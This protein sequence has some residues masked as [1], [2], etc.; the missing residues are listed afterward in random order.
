MANATPCPELPDLPFQVVIA[1][2]PDPERTNLRL[3]FDRSMEAITN[4]AQDTGYTL[5]RYS[6]PWQTTAPHTY[7]SLADDNAAQAQRKEKNSYPGILAFRNA[8]GG[9]A[10]AVLLVG[11]SPTEGY[12][13]SQLEHALSFEPQLA[14]AGEPLS[15][16]GPCFSG[17]L[18]VLARAIETQEAFSSRRLKI[19]SGTASAGEAW[20]K[21]NA[22]VKSHEHRI[23]S[24]TF[25]RTNE[26][27]MHVLTDFLRTNLGWSGQFASLSEGGTVFGDNFRDIFSQQQRRHRVSF[28]SRPL[29]CPPGIPE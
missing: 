2:V 14:L 8:S 22:R 21:F 1:F 25:L 23:Q 7:G 19:F 3:Y 17:T 6:L 15:L 27:T 24:A 11:E 16:M 20:K 18:A 10:L 9:P 28:S 26:N 4:A 5:F 29:S 12:R 13:V